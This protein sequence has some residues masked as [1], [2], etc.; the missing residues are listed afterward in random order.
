M[1]NNYSAVFEA[2]K[3]QLLE[4]A[5]KIALFVKIIHTFEKK[6]LILYFVTEMIKM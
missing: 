1:D 2:I 4:K 3:N 5:L 6:S